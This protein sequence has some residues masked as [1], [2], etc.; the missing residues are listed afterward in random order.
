MNP[1]IEPPTSRRPRHRADWNFA[2]FVVGLAIATF[3]LGGIP[4]PGDRSGR[5]ARA[6]PADPAGYGPVTGRSP[7]DALLP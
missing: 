5:N 7:A 6:T 3:V 4:A 2:A 1:F